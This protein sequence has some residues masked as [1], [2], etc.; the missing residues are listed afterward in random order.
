MGPRDP[1]HADLASLVSGLAHE[2]KNPIST[3]N[4]TLQLMREDI[5]EDAPRPSSRFLGKIDMLLDETKRLEQM[6]FEFMRIAA[7]SELDIHAEDLSEL[8]EQLLIF[9]SA[10]L[11]N[12][13]IVVVSQLDRSLNDVR[14]DKSLMK[15]VLLNLLKNGIQAVEGGEGGTITVQTNRI[16]ESAVI[17]IIDTGRG[18][19][20]EEL[21]QAF[22]AYYSTKPEGTGLGLP[23]V[24][25]LVTLHGGN[26]SCEST[27]GMGT[28]FRLALPL[29]G[30]E[31]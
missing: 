16:G 30:P 31:Q 25:R 4:I 24:Q 10:E 17:E 22:H 27:E 23:M 13:G 14:L 29:E 20:E 2:I 3:I 7:P 9:V 19:S 11:R 12:R 15:Q 18:M 26:I 28:R 1:E 6:L 21:S 8:I 5:A